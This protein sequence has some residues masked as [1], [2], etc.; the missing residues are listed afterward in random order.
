MLSA[1]SNHPESPRSNFMA[2]QM[3]ISA[4]DNSE[5][6]APVLADAARSFLNNGLAADPRCINCLFGLIVLDLHRDVQSDPAV[7]ARL[8][9]SLRSGYVGPTKVS[10]SQF[11]YLVK[12]QRGQGTRLATDDLES[13]FEAALS[14]PGWGSSGRA[15][16]ENAYRE[17]YE[18]VAQDLVAALVHAR[19]AVRFW[20]QQW[21]YHMNLVRVLRKLR[22]TDEALAA[23]AV[24]AQVAGN[25]RQRRETE[26]T[27]AELE[28]ELPN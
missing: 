28:R 23:I 24:A 1:A 15:G 19:V 16:I 9:E 13:I 26:L 18:F 8:T 25:E 7:I 14:N 27:L 20:P 5:D 10:L 21:N 2:A 3:L 17:Y 11:S 22:R 6:D 12:W 4:L